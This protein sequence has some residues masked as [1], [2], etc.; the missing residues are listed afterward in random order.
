MGPALSPSE[1]LL[2][3]FRARQERL[4][5]ANRRLQHLRM[6]A[7]L[8]KMAEAHDLALEAMHRAQGLEREL[9]QAKQALLPEA[10]PVRHPPTPPVDRPDWQRQLDELRLEVQQLRQKLEKS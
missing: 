9:H 6:G 1:R 4:E 3:D 7:E 8:L 10:E 2:P 5:I